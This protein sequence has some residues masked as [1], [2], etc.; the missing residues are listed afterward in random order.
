MGEKEV[1]VAQMGWEALRSCT[2]LPTTVAQVQG[3]A[4]YGDW[5][6][7]KRRVDSDRWKSRPP[8]VVS[9]IC[10]TC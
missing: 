9:Y 6:R 3:P 4:P 7:T 2:V 1:S 10:V 8:V 5:Q